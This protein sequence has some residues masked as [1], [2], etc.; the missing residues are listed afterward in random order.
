MCS[1][2]DTLPTP[3]NTTN[4]QMGHMERPM[5][6]ALQGDRH[7]GRHPGRVKSCITQGRYWCRHDEVFVSLTNTLEHKR[8]KKP[9]C[10]TTETVKFVIEEEKPPTTKK[11]KEQ[12]TANQA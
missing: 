4:V 10:E 8:Y 5:E 9:P 3:T 1:V 6:Q 7:H 2:Y 12:H 11:C